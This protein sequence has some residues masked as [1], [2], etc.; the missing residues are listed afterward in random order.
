MDS[1]KFIE[2]LAVLQKYYGRV[3][4]PEMVKFYWEALK[5][6]SDED[7]ASAAENIKTE[8]K[9]TAVTPF[10]LIVHFLEACNQSGKG[11]A[12]AVMQAINKAITR[13]GGYESVDFG[14]RALHA[15]ID[16]FGGWAAICRWTQKEWDINEGR[17]REGY[18]YARNFKNSG[19]DYVMGM[20]DAQNSA[21]GYALTAPKKIMIGHEGEKKL[22]TSGAF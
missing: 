14:D 19:P 13:Y 12:E 7:W 11:R 9:P 1:K 21:M 8:W 6:L 18:M 4:I 3:L 2:I 16:R 22:L 5:N 20:F 17:F 10:P 15:T